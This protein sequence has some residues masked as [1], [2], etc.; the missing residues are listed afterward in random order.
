[1]LSYHKYLHHSPSLSLSRSLALSLS[2]LKKCTATKLLTE[3][4]IPA[5]SHCDQ[6]FISLPSFSPPS[7][8]HPPS[9]SDEEN[10]SI[11]HQTMVSFSFHPLLTCSNSN[12]YNCWHEVHELV[13]AH[14]LRLLCRCADH[15]HFTWL[16]QGLKQSREVKD[17]VCLFVCF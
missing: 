16:R 17:C 3:F 5:A 6:S 12:S 14:E 1:M 2:L 13:S 7:L 11:Q 15:F 9:F 8:S 4:T 10:V